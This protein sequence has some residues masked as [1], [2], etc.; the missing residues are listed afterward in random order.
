MQELLHLSG[1]NASF[2][3]AVLARRA[4][5]LLLLAPGDAGARGAIFSRCPPGAAPG[6]AACAVDERAAQWHV[7]DFDLLHE[8]LEGC[9]GYKLE[10]MSL[11]GP[12]HQVVLA[13]KPRRWRPRVLARALPLK[14]LPEWDL[15]DLRAINEPGREDWPDF[16]DDLEQEF[17]DELLATEAAELEKFAKEEAAKEAAKAEL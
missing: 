1:R 16:P 7:W 6:A 9:M 3:D 11:Q 2:D 12:N 10:F 8:A 4:E 17:I 13:R 15:P 14:W 5:E